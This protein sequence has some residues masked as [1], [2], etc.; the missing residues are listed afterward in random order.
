MFYTLRICPVVWNIC[1]KFQKYVPRQETCGRSASVSSQNREAWLKIWVWAISS[2]SYGPIEWHLLDQQPR[3]ILLVSNAAV[4][5]PNFAAGA[6]H[7]PFYFSTKSDQIDVVRAAESED[8]HN[9][10]IWGRVTEIHV[11]MT[12][13]VIFLSSLSSIKYIIINVKWPTES[14]NDIYFVVQR[15]ITKF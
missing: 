9:F 1:S 13:E 11:I 12:S 15:H 2:K 14:K 6:E 8:H 7:P 5:G 10:A 4:I 3:G